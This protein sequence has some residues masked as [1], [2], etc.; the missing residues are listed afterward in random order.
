MAEF[1]LVLNDLD[2]QKYVETNSLDRFFVFNSRI[3]FQFLKRL[4]EEGFFDEYSNYV[5]TYKNKI[6]FIPI[7]EAIKQ[8][9]LANFE[10]ALSLLREHL[11]P[12]NI[13][14]FKVKEEK[15]YI[16]RVFLQNYPDVEMGTVLIKKEINEKN[17]N[18]ALIYVDHILSMDN[19][20][21]YAYY[22]KAELC[23]E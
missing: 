8:K 5:T 4:L 18:K 16:S 22:W 14:T 3:Q 12:E 20:P 10:K 13:D 17:Y 15:N 2:F 11:I 9:E 23:I 21:R 7:L 6:S 19:P 1:A